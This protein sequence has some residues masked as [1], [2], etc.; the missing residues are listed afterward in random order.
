[1]KATA[2]HPFDELFT[3]VAEDPA[4]TQ[5]TYNVTKLYEYI[6][7]HQSEVLLVKVPIDDEH[8]Q[9]C[10]D[11]RGVEQDRLQVLAQNP[12]YLQKPIVFVKMPD[13]EHLLVDGTHRYVIYWMVK[14]QFIPAYIVPFAL[15]QPFI[16][17]DLPDSPEDELMAWSGISLI[18]KLATQHTKEPNDH[19]ND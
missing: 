13:D 2:V 9:Y 11:K 5:T 4:G 8:G 16:V 7:T 1:M 17:E 3:H 19:E 15:A 10:M 6:S 12:K 14:G 18:H